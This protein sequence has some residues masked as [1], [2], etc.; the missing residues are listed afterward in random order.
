VNTKETI[1]SQTM[2]TIAIPTPVP[3][4]RMN[5]ACAELATVKEEDYT[6]VLYFKVEEGLEARNTIHD[7]LSVFGFDWLDMTNGQAASKDGDFALF[8]REVRACAN[9][10]RFT[11]Y[12]LFRM[13]YP[14]M[15]LCLTQEMLL[16]MK[17]DGL[18]E[19]GVCTRGSSKQPSAKRAR[20]TR[21]QCESFSTYSKGLLA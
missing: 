4:R 21:W 1:Q 5:A 17:E 6:M 19:F 2:S 16:A 7:H 12:E 18:L 14:G 9:K 10:H 11:L 15:G 3:N 20:S 8:C 13:P